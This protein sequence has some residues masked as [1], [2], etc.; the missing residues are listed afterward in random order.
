MP[1]GQ[2]I[3]VA[4]DTHI[5]QMFF[6]EVCPPFIPR[7]NLSALFSRLPNRP[8][9]VSR[10]DSAHI[11]AACSNAG[12]LSD[13]NKNQLSTIVGEWTPA[14][15]DC[16]K[17]LNGRGV[18]ARYDGSISQGAPIFGNC[19]DVTGYGSSFSQDYKVFLRKIWEAQVSSYV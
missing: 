11:Q 8:Q 10:N 9:G 15:T 3:N 18:G 7:H 4:L 19:S 2:Y 1:R 12:P 17:Y 14:M 16:A 13:F 5:Y 6:N